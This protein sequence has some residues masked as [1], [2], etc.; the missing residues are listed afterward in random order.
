MV[1]LDEVIEL[2]D[3]A[4]IEAFVAFRQLHVLVAQLQHTYAG[5]VRQ[6]VLARALREEQRPG[7]LE[8]DERLR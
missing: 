6:L 8:G 2:E 4:P 1:F 5:R 3:F 7:T